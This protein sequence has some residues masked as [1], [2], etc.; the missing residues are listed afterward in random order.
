M[1]SNIVEVW[2][3]GQKRDGRGRQIFDQG[4]RDR[5]IERYRKSGQ[6]QRAFAEQEGINYTTF[7]GWLSR[8]R[9]G[10]RKGA[11]H[12]KGPAFTEVMLSSARGDC[13][14][15]WAVEV[16]LPDRTLVRGQSAGEVAALVKLLQD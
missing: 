12:E 1:E 4:E 16:V 5:L 3:E 13:A 14:G 15:S 8:R 2:D 10:S 7:V 6:T 11:S 9:K